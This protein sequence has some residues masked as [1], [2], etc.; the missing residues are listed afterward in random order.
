VWHESVNPKEVFIRDF[1]KCQHCGKATPERLRG[2]MKDSAPELD[3]ILPLVLGGAHSYF[4]TQCLCRKCNSIKGEHS[5]SEPKLIGVTDLTPYKTAKYPPLIGDRKEMACACGCG[6]SFV[7]SHSNLT[8][9][10]HGHWCHSVEA[11]RSRCGNLGRVNTGI[12]AIGRAG[13]RIKDLTPEERRAYMSKYRKTTS[14]QAV[15]KIKT[16]NRAQQAQDNAQ[17]IDSS[18]DTLRH[19]QGTATRQTASIAYDSGMSPRECIRRA[20]WGVSA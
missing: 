19:A 14:E 13:K 9:C 1:W 2:M 18:P 17:C 6:E 12:P 4:N 8:G 5:E 16:Y 20:I 3:H 15:F 7:P 11:Q 10:K